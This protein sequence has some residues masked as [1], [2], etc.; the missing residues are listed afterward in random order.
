MLAE[1]SFLHHFPEGGT[2]AGPA[3]FTADRDPTFLMCL[4]MSL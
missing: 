3:V 2:I 1:F 4:A